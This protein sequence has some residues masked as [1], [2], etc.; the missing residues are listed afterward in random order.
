MKLAFQ[1]SYPGGRFHGSQMQPALRTV[2]GEFIVACRALDLFS[3]WRTAG[4]ALSGRTDRGV[5]ARRQV[6]AFMTGHPDR[7]VSALNLRLP[8]DIWCTGY[9][10]VD[11]AFHP[12]YDALSRTYRY[13]FLQTPL[14]AAVMDRGARHYV[15]THDFSLFSRGSE[16]S[17]VRTVL[18]TAVFEDDGFLVFEV[19]AE[20]FLWNMVRRMAAALMLVGA[21]T[22]DD[23]C[24]AECLDGS[25][26]RE[27]LP[28]APPEGLILWDIEYD[29]EFMPMPVDER[30]HIYCR[31]LRRHHALLERVLGVIG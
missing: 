7:A 10:R 17:P 15:G 31:D 18:R 4:F 22:W 1:F 11:E 12:R 25:G 24:I 21:G 27:G 30:S 6:C 19:T 3:D 9:A 2:E 14:D 8:A 5:H 29:I 16:R 28:S 23:A 26:K 20:S 13:Y